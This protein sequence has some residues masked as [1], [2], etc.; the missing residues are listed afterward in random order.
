MT[1]F[2]DKR[3]LGYS[4]IT[5]SLIKLVATLLLGFTFH[6]PATIFTGIVFIFGLIIVLS[7]KKKK[8]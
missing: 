8:Y 1:F 3:I 6:V 7:S 2:K 5:A 4:L